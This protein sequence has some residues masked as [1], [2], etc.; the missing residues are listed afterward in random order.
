MTRK[1]GVFAVIGG[2]VGAVMTIAAGLVLPL[3][4]QSS[5]EHA[6]GKV[7][8]TELEVLR[9]DGKPA[10]LLSVTN[11]SG[12]VGVFGKDGGL[13]TMR[14]GEHGGVVSANGKGSSKGEAI[15]AV[16]A[17][18]N[19]AVATWDKNGYRLANLK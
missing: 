13:A 6:F 14:I 2:V 17:Y 5:A 10:V 9:P 15:L 3:G 12:F 18:G 11:D 1:E 16:N 7:T 4:A 19:G 8:C